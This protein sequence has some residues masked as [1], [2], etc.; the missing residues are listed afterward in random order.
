LSFLLF[1]QNTHQDKKMNACGKILDRK[2][3]RWFEPKIV[4]KQFNRICRMVYLSF[5]HFILTLVLR[6]KQRKA[7]EIGT[8]RCKR[9]GSAVGYLPHTFFFLLIKN[10]KVDLVY[11]KTVVMWIYPKEIGIRVIFARISFAWYS[12]ALK[13]KWKS[14]RNLERRKT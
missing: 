13:N 1:P 10:K 11:G 3:W 2:Q 9:W 12:I 8:V 5:I 6:V 14:S 7:K 4:E